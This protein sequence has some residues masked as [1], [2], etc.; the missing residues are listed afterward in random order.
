MNSDVLPLH[1][2]KQYFEAHVQIY[3]CA[4]W[5]R[6]GTGWLANNINYIYKT[7]KKSRCSENSEDHPRKLSW[8]VCKAVNQTKNTKWNDGFQ[9][10]I[11][12]SKYYWLTLKW[13]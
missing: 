8:W 12:S 1:K 10:I 5:P 4:N 7:M 9:I 2:I 13:T 6:N 3:D 11:L